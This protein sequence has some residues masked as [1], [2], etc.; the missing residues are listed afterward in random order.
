MHEQAGKEEHAG[1][2]EAVAEQHHQVEAEPAH[3]V[4]ADAEMRVVDDGVIE[5]HQ[6]GDEGARAV[7]RNDA[8]RGERDL[9]VVAGSQ[10]RRKLPNRRVG[11]VRLFGRD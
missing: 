2:E 11:G 1:H 5:H 9:A 10:H 6:Q 8:V 4:A 3:A 7:E